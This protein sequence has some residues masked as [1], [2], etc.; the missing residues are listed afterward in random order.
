MSSVLQPHPRVPS[1][2]LSVWTS[3]LL[4]LLIQLPG[5]MWLSPDVPR[6][7]YHSKL[8]LNAISSM[9][10]F[11]PGRSLLLLNISW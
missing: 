4:S 11:F 3:L 8:G 1:P 7:S 9:K 5:S 6:L 10:S 2:T